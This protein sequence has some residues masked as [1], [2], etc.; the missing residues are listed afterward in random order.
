[1][2][3]DPAQD[4]GLP[5]LFHPAETG[6][7]PQAHV[8]IPSTAVTDPLPRAHVKTRCRRFRSPRRIRRSAM[9]HRHDRAK[10]KMYRS[11]MFVGEARTLMLGVGAAAIFFIIRALAI[12]RTTMDFGQASTRTTSI[13]VLYV[14]HLFSCKASPGSTM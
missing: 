13:L 3:A 12:C 9:A 8:E 5:S 10:A 1:M 7:L 4:M 2:K 14:R 11:P 6:P